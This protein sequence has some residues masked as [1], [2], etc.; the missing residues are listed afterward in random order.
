M[1]IALKVYVIVNV[2]EKVHVR[3]ADTTKVDSVYI[4]LEK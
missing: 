3:S 2:H 4:M 1:K